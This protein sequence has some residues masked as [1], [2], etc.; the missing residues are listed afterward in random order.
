MSKTSAAAARASRSDHFE[1]FGLPP[2]YALDLGRLESAYRQVVASVHPDRFAHAGDAERRASM[3][4]ATGVN[5]AYRTL[6]DPVRRGQY[7][8]AMHGVELGLETHTAMPREF[9]MEQ[10]ELREKLEAARSA[11][12]LALLERE[13]A[14]LKETLQAQ[15]A[16]CIDERREYAGAADLVRKLMFLDKLDE[17]LNAAYEALEA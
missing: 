12:A 16:G 7:L 15:I 6:R 3:Q 2:A 8:L 4:A 1:L 10:M 5:E 13:L 14:G 9:L 17:D 11:D